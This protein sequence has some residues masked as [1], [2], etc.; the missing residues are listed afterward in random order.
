MCNNDAIEAECQAFTNDDNINNALVNDFINNSDEEWNAED[1]AN[2]QERAIQNVANAAKII[3]DLRQTPLPDEQISFLVDDLDR[4]QLLDDLKTYMLENNITL[5]TLPT[6][7]WLGQGLVV[8]SVDQ[9]DNN[10]L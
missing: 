4:Q 2:D 1:I 3:R 6:G 8:S 5:Q 9:L 10:E 7:R